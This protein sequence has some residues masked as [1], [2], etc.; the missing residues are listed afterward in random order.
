MRFDN[1]KTW[2]TNGRYYANDGEITRRIS[3]DEYMS[4]NAQR[5]AWVTG[6]TDKLHDLYAY[7]Y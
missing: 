6:D 4:F 3:K 2:S 1:T 7:G 5:D